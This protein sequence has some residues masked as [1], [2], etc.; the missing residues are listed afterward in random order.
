MIMSDDY[1]LITCEKLWKLSE[2]G[3]TLLTQGAKAGD[4]G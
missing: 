1:F 2:D 3:K 4:A